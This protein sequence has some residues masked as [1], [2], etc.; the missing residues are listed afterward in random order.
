MNMHCKNSLLEVI[1]LQI[2]PRLVD[3]H[4]DFAPLELQEGAAVYSPSTPDISAFANL[5]V[6][7][8][9]KAANH[10]IDQL[11]RDGVAIQ[12][13]FLQL[14]AP[15]AR[16][17]GWMWEQ[18]EAD[19]SQV[20]LGLMRLQQITHRLGYEYQSGPQTAGRVRRMM[21]A[22]APGS[23]HLLGLSMVSEFFRK[24]GWQVVV[25]IADNQAGLLQTV[26]NEWFDL[27]GLSVGLSGQ[28][29]QLPQLVAQLKAA[30]RNPGVPVMLGGAAF[31]DSAV[32]HRD[33]GADAIS[34]D[35]TEAVALASLLTQQK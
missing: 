26:R 33:L 16:H 25:E 8:S 5:C 32:T 14:V 28:I 18:D 34:T 7:D 31:L 27:V 10:F 19:F 6:Q 29:L 12:I 2:I 9:A 23:Q 11:V 24:D 15:A 3:S 30:S 13:L 4:S 22:S 17:L 21:I 20:T 1:E 35:A